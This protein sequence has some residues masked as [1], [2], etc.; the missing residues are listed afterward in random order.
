MKLV[1]KIDVEKVFVKKTI[2]AEWVRRLS[3]NTRLWV[4]I[5]LRS[6]SPPHLFLKVGPGGAKGMTSLS[7]MEKKAQV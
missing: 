4:R 6:H 3:F 7:P 1:V 2:E 5:L